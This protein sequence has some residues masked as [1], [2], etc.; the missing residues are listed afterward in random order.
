MNRKITRQDQQGAFVMRQVITVDCECFSHAST[1]LFAQSAH[2][3]I[4]LLQNSWIQATFSPVCAT[5]LQTLLATSFFGIFS[6][7][8]FVFSAC[9]IPY[10]QSCLSFLCLLLYFSFYQ[11]HLYF[12]CKCDI[13]LFFPHSLLVLFIFHV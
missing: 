5:W 2:C 7:F 11:S 6:S 3:I 4:Y 10:S 8:L 9:D 12:S 13:I 1:H